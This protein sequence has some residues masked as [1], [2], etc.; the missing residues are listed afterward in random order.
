M[1]YKTDELIYNYFKN[2]TNKTIQSLFTSA[3]NT[4]TTAYNKDVTN[5]KS[6]YGD[7]WQYYIQTN[8]FDSEGGTEQSYLLSQMAS[9]LLSDFKNLIFGDNLSGFKSLLG[10]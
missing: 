1:A 9:T 10:F 8:L 2:S 3:Q 6:E 5:Y 7:K 4:A